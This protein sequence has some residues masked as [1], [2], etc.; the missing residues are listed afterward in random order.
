MTFRI[1]TQFQLNLVLT[2]KSENK[3]CICEG[4]TKVR[5]LVRE[6]KR[7]RKN[8]H[9]NAHTHLSLQEGDG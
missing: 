1:S 6:R 7:E 5:G 9:T 8:T 2:K 4:H 3:V